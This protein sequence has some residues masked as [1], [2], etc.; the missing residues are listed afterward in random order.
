MNDTHPDIELRMRAMLRQCSGVER[1]KMGCAMFDTSKRLVLASLASDASPEQ[2][3]I[4]CFLRFYGY[5]YD[6]PAKT[7]ILNH[8]SAIN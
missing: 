3:K 8:L 6:E 1:L 7:K 5:D 4:Y 2:I